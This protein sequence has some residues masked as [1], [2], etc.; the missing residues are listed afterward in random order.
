M[1]SADQ[2]DTTRAG[3]PHPVAAGLHAVPDDTRL[4]RRSA[5][6]MALQRV[7]DLVLATVAAVVFAIPAAVIGIVVKATSPGPV[8]FKQERV[9]CDGELFTV[10]KFRTM[11]NG[12]H[13]EVLA[14]EA[15]R[16]AYQDNDF[17]LRPDDPRIT[18]IGRW[19]RKTSLDEV[20]QLVNVLRGEM[21]VV[22]VRPLLAEELALRPVRDQLLYHQHR[23]GMTGLWQ[24]EGR[25]TVRK[26]DRLALDRQ[27]LETWSVWSDVK[28]AA[29]T[30]FAL[31]RIHHAH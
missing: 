27:Y 30:P 25:S 15:A 6:Q 19:L 7:F 20:P 29:R 16:R 11:R 14:D 31:V 12:T 21:S 18:P 13:H 23:P 4:P 28:I 8:L 10:W 17:K 24:V 26:T 2:I 22:G 1:S 9:G 3:A 5:T